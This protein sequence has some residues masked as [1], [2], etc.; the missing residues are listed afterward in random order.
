MKLCLIQEPVIWSQLSRGWQ[1]RRDRPCLN[2]M[3]LFTCKPTMTCR[4]IKEIKYNH[5]DYLH[6]NLQKKKKNQTLQDL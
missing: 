6:A 1:G 3:N 4:I 2:Q 5:V